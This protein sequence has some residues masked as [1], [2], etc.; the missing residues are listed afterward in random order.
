MALSEEEKAVAAKLSD[1]DRL[2]FI[3]FTPEQ[4]VEFMEGFKSG[5]QERQ[6]KDINSFVS[7][8]FNKQ[9][10][11]KEPKVS[12]AKI[13]IFQI[14]SLFVILLGL[15]LILLGVGIPQQDRIV[16]GDYNADPTVALKGALLLAFWI[17][18]KPS[19]KAMYYRRRVKRWMPSVVSLFIFYVLIYA[20]LFMTDS[21]GNMG[22]AQKI[23]FGTK[24]AMFEMLLLFGVGAFVIP[25]TFGFLVAKFEYM[26]SNIIDSSNAKKATREEN[27]QEGGL[28]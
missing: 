4:R 19:I 2:T 1:T 27:K 10:K 21:Y 17:A 7:A 26:L 16:L 28:A 20:C 24:E 12:F 6:S 25:T 23:I 9:P 8:I 5:E 11:Q 3:G 14:I 18:L 15:Y 13:V 22:K